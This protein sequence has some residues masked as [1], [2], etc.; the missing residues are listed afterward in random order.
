MFEQL[1]AGDWDAARMVAV[2]VAAIGERFGDQNLFAFALVA[3]GRALIKQGRVRQG[4]AL[5]D[6]VELLVNC[7]LPLE[8]T[9]AV[10]Y[11]TPYRL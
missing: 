9:L 3:Q 7:K 6:E 2:H 5:L 8:L 10:V 11:G 1:D 4:L